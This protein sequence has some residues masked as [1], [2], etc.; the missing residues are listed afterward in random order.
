MFLGQYDM[1]S[2]IGGYTS[3]SYSKTDS[4]ITSKN[5]LQNNHTVIDN[6]ISKKNIEYLLKIVEL[7]NNTNRK[8]ILMR[9]PLNSYYEGYTNEFSYKKILTTQLKGITY[10][11][12]SKFPLQNNEYADLEHLNM[13]GAAK[14]SNW[15]NQLDRL[16]LLKNDNKQLFIN[17]SIKKMSIIQ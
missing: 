14:F 16:G 5:N 8:I 6:G 12:F 9:S 11:D 2:S 7:C 3:L 15:F 4:L 17:N 13:K 10:L 1:S